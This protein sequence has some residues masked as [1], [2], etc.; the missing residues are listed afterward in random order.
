MIL[1]NTLSLISSVTRK[2]SR[3]N[4]PAKTGIL[5][6]YPRWS[7][8]ETDAAF[9]V[10]VIL[11]FLMKRAIN[12]K[13]KEKKRQY[14][15]LFSRVDVPAPWRMISATSGTSGREIPTRPNITTPYLVSRLLCG[16]IPATA[17]SAVRS[18]ESPAAS[19][20]AV[21]QRYC[22]TPAA[23]AQCCCSASGRSLE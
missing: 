13:T 5:T 16:A 17:R 6:L 4:W 23:S 11:Q 15:R 21:P 3:C 18:C 7:I 1:P 2:S 8:T 12:S 19:S 9:T 14:C 10:D 20:V 22:P